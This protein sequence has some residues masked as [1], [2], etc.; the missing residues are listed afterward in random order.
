MHERI[1]KHDRDIRLARTQTSDVSERYNN[2][3]HYPVWDQVKFIGQ[4]PHW[5]TL[6]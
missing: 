4:D 3:R 2:F 1:K 5:Y 6:G